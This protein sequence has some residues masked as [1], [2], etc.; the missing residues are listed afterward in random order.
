[1]ASMNDVAQGVIEGNVDKVKDLTASLLESGIDPLEIINQGLIVGMNT[2]GERFKAGDMFVPEVLMCAKAMS[3]GMELV[4]SRLAGRKVQSAGKL[5]IGTVKSDLHDIG[6]NLVAM[7]VESAGF[8]VINLGVDVDPEKFVNAIKEYQPD[9]VG[10]SAL[11]TT[12]LPYMKETIEAIE[13]A[14]LRDQ[15]KIIIGGAPVT[16]NYADQIGADGYAPEAASATE[17]C[18]KLMGVA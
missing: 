11:L 7:M 9:I 1:M 16:Q 10:M 15:V 13:E 2:V 5:L 6:K 4:K 14:G 3:S 12:T 18:K 8:E 17:L